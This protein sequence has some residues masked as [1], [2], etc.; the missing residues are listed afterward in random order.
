MKNMN[1][2]NIK[3]DL[4]KIRECYKDIILDTL[5]ESEN[6][7]ISWNNYSSGISKKMYAKEF[8]DLK[9]NRQY[10][11]LLK[12]NGFIQCYYDFSNG[13]LNK[14]KLAYY[15]YPVVLQE[16]KESVEEYYD[17]TDDETLGEYYFDIYKLIETKLGKR[18]SDEDLQEIKTYCQKFNLDYD[19]YQI[20]L[21]KFDKKYA[22]TNT[23]HIRID[24]DNNVKSHHKTEIQYSSINNIR[25]PLNK[26]ISPFLFMDFIVRYEFPEF[27]NYHKITT[28][29]KTNYSIAL[30]HS[31]NIKQFQENNIFI[32]HI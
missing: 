2:R 31:G 4:D 1:F 13:K 19:E 11:F 20:L 10:S 25:L 28:K 8:E 6:E 23:S 29:Y 30:K 9:N 21:D 26:I 16:N 18:V 15:P 32:S 12:N 7:I 3:D 5:V 17:T 14:A 22:L 24:F 27:Y